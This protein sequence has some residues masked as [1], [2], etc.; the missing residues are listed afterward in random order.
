MADIDLNIAK[1]E[2]VLFLGNPAPAKQ[3]FYGYWLV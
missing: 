3:L 1:G 2:F